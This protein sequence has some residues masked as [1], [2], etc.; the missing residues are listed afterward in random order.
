MNADLG[1]SS[2]PSYLFAWAGVSFRLP[3]AW[4]LSNY[5]FSR[6][7]TTVKFE[8]DYTRRLQV[9]WIPL[10]RAG[11]DITKI[12]Q[13]YAKAAR[14]LTASAI[15][16][17]EIKSLPAPWTAFLYHMPDGARLLTVFALLPDPDLFCF[18]QINFA[19]ADP[20]R[21]AAVAELITSA[22]ATHFAGFTPWSFYDVSFELP[23]DFR[24]VNTSFQAGSKL[25][26]FQWKSRRL[27]LWHFSLAEVLLKNRQLD[28]WVADF[29]NAYPG[30]KGR[31]F[32]LRDDGS[33]DPRR[34]WR[35]RL[36]HHE[37]IAR[38]CYRYL[39]SWQHDPSKNQIRLTVFNYRKEND[40]SR[41]P[42]GLI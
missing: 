38:W 23:A 18:M 33:I 20:E 37:E 1:K 42:E 16:S 34:T 10:K 4:Q 30:I 31:H 36:A 7:T 24:L 9:E 17:K 41:I 11:T 25:L 14:K 26:I 29:L 35:Y 21:P 12:H 40:L 6:H 15:K 2:L 8:D 13:R 32:T 22:F 3:E 28:E 19:P 27:Y 39:I 5:S